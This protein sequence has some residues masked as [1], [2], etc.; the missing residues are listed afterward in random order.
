MAVFAN[1][2]RLAA[3]SLL[4]ASGHVLAEKNSDVLRLATTTST[5]NSG[6]LSY[7]LPDFEGRNNV[8]VQAVVVGTG[9]ALSHARNGDVDVILTHAKEDELKLVAEGAVINRQEIMYNEFVIVGPD[10][11]PA[12]I[13][14]WTNL[15]DAM[16]RIHTAGASFVSRG[17]D[18]GTHKKEIEI[19]AEIGVEPAGEWYFDVGQGMGKTL[20]IANELGAYTLTDK[21]TWLFIRD[22]LT[23]PLHVEGAADG[24]NLYGAMQVNHERHAN[25]NFEA[26]E[27]FIQWLTT[28]K[29]KQ[30]IADYKI[31]G[32]QL[33]Y[34]IL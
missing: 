29:V 13:H 27:K 26:A 30:M 2:A 1:F 9:R 28:D 20:Q 6:L 22:R 34:P 14:G 11:D 4:L 10:H 16:H 31:N 7:I 12:Q 21:G 15:S 24:K 3:L 17:D 32:E 25:V 18:S 5:E 33:F 19:W 8:W 23:L